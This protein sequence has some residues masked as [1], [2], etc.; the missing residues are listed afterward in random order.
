MGREV[1]RTLVLPNLK[2]YADMVLQPAFSDEGDMAQRH[3]AERCL[4]A[5]IVDP[6]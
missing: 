2:I 4:E 3:D 5:I 1:I 6:S